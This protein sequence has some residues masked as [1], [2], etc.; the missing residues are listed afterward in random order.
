MGKGGQFQK[1]KGIPRKGLKG[2]IPR[3]QW[4]GKPLGRRFP[5]APER[6]GKKNK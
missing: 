3:F 4:E 1:K 6:D 2:I 5:T